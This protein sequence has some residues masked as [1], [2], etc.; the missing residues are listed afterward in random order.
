MYFPLF[1]GL[2][3]TKDPGHYTSNKQNT[4]KGTEKRAS[5][6][7][8]LGSMSRQSGEFFMFY[9]YFIYPR[10][11]AEEADLQHQKKQK[12]TVSKNIGQHNKLSFS[13]W[14]F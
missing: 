14:A 10:F 7:E 11:G 5:Q 4:L 9:F 6:L 13:S 3:T 2:S 12:N 8:T 1:L